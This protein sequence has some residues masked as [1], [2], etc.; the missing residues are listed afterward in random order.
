[1]KR[2]LAAALVLL[3]GCGQGAGTASQSTPVP[4]KAS[5][6]NTPAAS[7]SARS[8]NVLLAVSE[9]NQGCFG[10]SCT[11][12]IAIVGIDGRVYARATFTPPQ[13]AVVGCEGSYV[14][15][16]VQVAAGAVY[17]L[18]NTGLVRRLSPSGA[19]SDVA[20]FP[21]HTSQQLMWFAV[22]PRRQQADG[23]D[24]GLPAPFGVLGPIQNLPSA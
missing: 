19:I 11:S 14:T 6:D 23:L 1:M 3:A 22:S 2:L 4:T 13:P 7:P 5:P 10:L 12:H 18:D 24:R 8:T 20:H 16:P 9:G 15:N 21:I 17:Y